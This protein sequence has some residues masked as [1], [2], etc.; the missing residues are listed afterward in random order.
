MLLKLD[1]AKLFKSALSE[2]SAQLDN[3]VG[4]VIPQKANTAEECQR[5][6]FSDALDGLERVA[7]AISDE[8]INPIYDYTMTPL[9]RECRCEP[10]DLSSTRNQVQ[11]LTEILTN[12]DDDL[13]KL[14]EE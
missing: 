13:S 2:I 4:S 12:L 9:E 6:A 7:N 14:Q 5:L 10:I 1:I 8:D 11:M 3:I